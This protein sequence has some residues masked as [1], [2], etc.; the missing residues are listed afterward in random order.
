M[1]M[2]IPKI[3]LLPMALAAVPLHAPVPSNLTQAQQSPVNLIHIEISG[4][5]NDKGQAVCSIYSSASWF[6]LKWRSDVLR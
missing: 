4:F 3:F 2:T 5:R 6:S 1:F